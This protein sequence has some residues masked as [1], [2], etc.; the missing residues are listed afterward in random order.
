MTW[1]FILQANYPHSGATGQCSRAHVTGLS[2]PAQVHVVSCD[3]Q[4]DAT[5]KGIHDWIVRHLRLA[6]STTHCSGP[7]SGSSWECGLDCQA[8]DESACRHVLV[9]VKNA[10]GRIDRAAVALLAAW[11][12]KASINS[13]VVIVLPPGQGSVD[14]PRQLRYF[15]RLTDY[16]I[17]SELGVEVL[18]AAGIGGAR[19]LFLSYRRSDTEAL[20][21]QVHKALVQRGFDIYLDRFSWTAGRQFPTEIAEQMA[22]KGVVLLLESQKLYR[23]RWTQWELSFARSYHIG[24]VALNVDAAA[25]QPGINRADRKSINLKAGKLSDPKVDEVVAFVLRRHSLAEMRRRIY[26]ETLLRSAVRMAGGQVKASGDGVFEV[27]GSKSL[28]LYLPSGRPGNLGDLS[29]VGRSQASRATQISPPHRLLAGQHNHLSPSARR[30]VE[31]I[32]AQCN[33]KLR[34]RSGLLSSVSGLIKKGQP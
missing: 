28:G 16:G 25:H 30:D 2:R 22:D 17:A 13:E 23:S 6:K 7:G 26:F 14:L 5:A 33:V 4:A 9:L 11:R 15:H 20:A 18:R 12:A 10:P 34:S 21:D 24:I 19:K 27:T 1:N 8:F 32:A 29:T 3:S 31:W